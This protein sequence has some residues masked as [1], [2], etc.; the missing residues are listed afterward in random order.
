M[1]GEPGGAGGSGFGEKV[2]ASLTGLF[3]HMPTS[4]PRGPIRRSRWKGCLEISG[5]RGNGHQ[6]L[7]GPGLEKA[8]LFSEIPFIPS[9]RVRDFWRPCLLPEC[10]QL[11]PVCEM[12]AGAEWHL[13]GHLRGTGKGSGVRRQRAMRDRPWPTPGV[14]QMVAIAAKGV[15]PLLGPWVGPCPVPL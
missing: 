10:P 8:D 13:P 4:W 1:T 5:G 15:W 9:G 2:V 3:P 14:G 7:K 6:N 11:A 12:M